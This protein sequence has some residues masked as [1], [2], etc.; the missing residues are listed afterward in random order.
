MRLLRTSIIGIVSASLL[1]MNVS[2]GFLSD[3]AETSPSV[4]TGESNESAV[5]ITICDEYFS[6]E[7]RACFLIYQ[8]VADI[9]RQLGYVM[10]NHNPELS[11]NDDFQN[12]SMCR[13]YMTYYGQSTKDEARILLESYTDD[14]I[15]AL[16]D[17]FPKAEFETIDVN[18][19]VPAVEEENLYAATYRC[20]R[21]ES[22]GEIVR[23]DGSGK[24]YN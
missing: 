5:E 11:F 21:D 13:L 24:I 17:S 23:G 8:S 12:I 7:D 4:E 2:A 10:Q 22:S 16:H 1:T 3:L 18:W 15:V 19:E 6:S 14:L 20:E 9:G